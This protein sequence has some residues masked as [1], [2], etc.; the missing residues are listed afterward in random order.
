MENLTNPTL[1]GTVQAAASGL[2]GF[3]MNNQL[4][5]VQAQAFK[6]AGYSFCLR[7]LS[8]NNQQ[9]KTDLDHAEALDILNAGLA[10]MA[11]QHVM[12]SGWTPSARLGSTYGTNA[13]INA[14]SIGLPTGINLWCDL[15]GIAVGTSAQTVI[16][17]CQA[18]YTAVNNAG[19][20]PGLYVGYD[21]VLTGD[22][23]YNNLSFQ[24]Y[25]K[26]GSLVPTVSVRG[27]QLI[28]SSNTQVLGTN[29]D[30]DTTQDDNLGGAV[31][32]LSL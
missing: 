25:W 21:S 19:Y 16:D 24:H 12:E 8:L 14:Q 26:S 27:Y 9:G 18:W 22:Q 11:V 15:E 20:V 32:W 29:I 5:L 17:Y 6:A 28:Q 30:T 31:L 2:T 7:Y 10:L 1:P 3:D 4:S 13:V 23:L